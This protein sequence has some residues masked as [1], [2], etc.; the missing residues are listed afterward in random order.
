MTKKKNDLVTC[1][2][3]H[4]PEEKMNAEHDEATVKREDAPPSSSVPPGDPT[5]QQANVLFAEPIESGKATTQSNG[6]RKKIKNEKN[7]SAS[8]SSSSSSSEDEGEKPSN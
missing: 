6:P 8:S 4:K 2:E 5:D 7:D 1:P 3:G